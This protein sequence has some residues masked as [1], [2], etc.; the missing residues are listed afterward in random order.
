MNPWTFIGALAA[1]RVAR[2]ELEA[3][4][5][6][7]YGSQILRWMRTPTFH[8]IVGAFIALAVI[9]TA[10]SAIALVR[11]TRGRRRSSRDVGPEGTE[12][13]EATGR[14]HTGGT[15]KRS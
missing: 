1:F 10:V 12:G 14:A 13:A 11:S 2:F 6:A 7:R 5:A 4:F 15:E 3:A 8:A 9:G